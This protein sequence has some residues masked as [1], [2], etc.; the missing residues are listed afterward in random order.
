MCYRQITRE[1]RYAIAL[2]RQAG[3]SLR[4]IGRHLHRS[5]SSIS[6]EL[7][8]NL[9]P[10][11]GYRPVIAQR[12]TQNRR[13]L[14]HR[15]WQFSEQ[16]WVGILRLLV[17]GLS[18][19]QIA[20]RL[21]RERRLWISPETIYRFIW[22]N[23]RRGGDLWRWLRGAAK[24]KRKR[25]G[26]YERR[27]RLAGKRPLSARPPIVARRGRIGDWEMDTMVGTGS[28]H[29]VLVLTE[30]KTGK[31][32]LGKLADRT[33]R[34]VRQRAIQL[35]RQERRRVWTLT[36]DNG[37]E[38]HQYAAIEGALGVEV[39]FAPP[40][41]AWERGTC[42]NTIGL[43]RQYLPRGANLAAVT[44]AECARIARQLNRRPRKRLGY[45]TPEER[46]APA[47]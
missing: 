43:I 32:R 19:E 37:T 24:Q 29:A 40:Y 30:R 4:A 28:R 12:K 14:G 46:Y 27:G 22:R 3:W 38:F 34:G 21:A 31:V 15:R 35:L 33:A 13:H 45:L 36:A 1:E 10:D 18:P 11:G 5:P 39:F 26:T 9:S 2:G 20:G 47:A 23:H 25:Y 44:Q 7:R 6:R 41:Q 16:D 42:E 17:Q 8:R